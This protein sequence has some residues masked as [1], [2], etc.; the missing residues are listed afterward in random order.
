MPIDSQG[1]RN[2]PDPLLS[3]LDPNYSQ[4]HNCVKNLYAQQIDQCNF[5][6]NALYSTQNFPA[7]EWKTIHTKG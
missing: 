5:C 2:G 1:L 4:Y 3:E 6:T 7:V